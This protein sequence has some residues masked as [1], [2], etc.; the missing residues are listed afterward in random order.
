MELRPGTITAT[1]EDVAVYNV[2]LTEALF[3]LLEEKSA[4]TTAEVTERLQRLKD[5]TRINITTR[6]EHC[7]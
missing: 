6:S 2:L 5:E 7:K 4:V 3:E 1:I